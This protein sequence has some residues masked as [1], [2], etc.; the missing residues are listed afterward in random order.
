MIQSLLADRFKMKVNRV[1]KQLPVYELVVA[2]GGAKLKP[3]NA[4]DFAAA[5]RP[6]DSGTSSSSG[7]GYFKAV[8]A[9]SADL[10]YGLSRF[11]SRELGR[12]VIDR[13]GLTG[14]YDFTLTWQP[15][16]TE[17]GAVDVSP[18]SMRSTNLDSAGPSIFTAIQEQLGLKLKPT[19]GPVEVLVVDHIERP[20][21]N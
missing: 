18:D 12:Q 13:T 7:P 4:A 17:R 5:G 6:P 19:V 20:S 14:K 1:V 2:N 11:V 15:F 3:E 21:E 9:S 16:S 8:G 10:A